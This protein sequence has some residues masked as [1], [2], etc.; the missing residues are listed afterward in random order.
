MRIDSQLFLFW[1]RFTLLH[2]ALL[3]PLSSL[4]LVL[5]VEEFVFSWLKRRIS[6][7]TFKFISVV[8]PLY[9]FCY[10]F[11]F[12]LNVPDKIWLGRVLIK[13]VRSSILW[14]ALLVYL[15]FQNFCFWS[16]LSRRKPLFGIETCPRLVPTYRSLARGWAFSWQTSL[17]NR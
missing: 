7:E 5:F 12:F 11:R 17:I 14:I 4:I 3:F 15:G 8:Q 9:T 10:L 16:T 13:W 1:S 6:F 2:D